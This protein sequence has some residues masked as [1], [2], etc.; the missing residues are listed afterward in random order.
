MLFKL[1]GFEFAP[2]QRAAEFGIAKLC[3]TRFVASRPV[4]YQSRK[5]KRADPSLA[6]RALIALALSLHFQKSASEPGASIHGQVLP[7]DIISV[8]GNQVSGR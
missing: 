3:A 5:R 6:L 8:R 1:C 2:N 4:R 7:V